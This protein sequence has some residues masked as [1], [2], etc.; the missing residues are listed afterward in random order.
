MNL[1]L[2]LFLPSAHASPWLVG[3]GVRQVFREDA[4]FDAITLS[5]GPT[6]GVFG[7]QATA[8]LGLSP[9]NASALDRTLAQIADAKGSA[10]DWSPGVTVDRATLGL[11]AVVAPQLLATPGLHGGPRAMIGLEGRWIEHGYLDASEAGEA[12]AG[13]DGWSLV[14]D[15]ASLAL[16]PV[17]GLGASLSPA[18]RTALRLD[19]QDRMLLLTEDGESVDGWSAPGLRHDLTLSLDAVLAL[20]GGR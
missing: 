8:G 5:G 7:V 15:G 18:P 14:D 9:L 1:L 12:I 19:L 3:A 16:S 20:G 11:L 6:W 2:T 17:L 13:L 4:V 10:D